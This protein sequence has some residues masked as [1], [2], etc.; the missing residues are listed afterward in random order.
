MINTR[1]TAPQQYSASQRPTGQSAD[2]KPAAE[3][4]AGQDRFDLTGVPTAVKL[5]DMSPIWGPH[6]G[7][8]RIPMGVHGLA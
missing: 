3:P 1:T 6:P 7:P 2:E 4:Q 8:Y 5:Y